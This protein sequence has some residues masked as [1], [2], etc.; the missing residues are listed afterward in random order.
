MR[1]ESG[2]RRGHAPIALIPRFK[3]A[4]MLTSRTAPL[5]MTPHQPFSIAAVARR[6]PSK[7]KSSRPFASTTNISPDD[8]CRRTSARTTRSP[9]KFTTRI[10]P[11]KRRALPYWTRLKVQTWA[12][13]NESDRSAVLR[14]SIST[15]S[16]PVNGAHWGSRERGVD[17]R[18][19]LLGIQITN[20]YGIH[21]YS[22]YQRTP[23]VVS[24][25]MSCEVRWRIA[26][27]ISIPSLH[28]SQSHPLGM[29]PQR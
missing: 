20:T 6:S 5:M 22:G 15:V 2:A 18:S 4:R 17:S 12:S 1:P 19:Q 13:G 21:R 16:R 25:V 11:K 29:A 14:V 26:G 10:G 7:A 23:D 27:G 28:W 24:A 9:S 3:L 8:F